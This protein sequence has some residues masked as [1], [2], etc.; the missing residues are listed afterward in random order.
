M[1]FRLFTLKLSKTIELHDLA[2]GEL[3]AT[4]M[5]QTH[6]PTKFSVVVFILV[7]FQLSTLIR[8]VCVFVLILF[9]KRFQIDA[10]SMKALSILVW[11][12]GLNASKCMRFQTKTHEGERRA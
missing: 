1:R 9:Q 7:R 2:H 12:Q 3:Y 5:L 10:V 6:A 4:H 8:Y 11:T